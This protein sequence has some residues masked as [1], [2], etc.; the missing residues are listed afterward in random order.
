MPELNNN[1][2]TMCVVLCKLMLPCVCVYFYFTRIYYFNLI[3]THR[4]L[5]LLQLYVLQLAN[6]FKCVENQSINC[7]ALQ[8][9]N[10]ASGISKIWI[11]V[12]HQSCLGT[13]F[14]FVE[15]LESVITGLLSSYS[16]IQFAMA[17]LANFCPKIKFKNAK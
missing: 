9:I 17:C 2:A 5:Q 16:L 1:L 4:Q 7:L 10:C 15:Q 8:R 12:E 14:W 11:W 6:N 3:F 13:N